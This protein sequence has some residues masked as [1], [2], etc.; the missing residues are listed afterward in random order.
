MANSPSATANRTTTTRRG[1]VGKT[2]L[3]LEVMVR[4]LGAANGRGRDDRTR[5]QNGRGKGGRLNR[6]L[7]SAEQA[8]LNEICRVAGGGKLD[9]DRES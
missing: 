8:F 5:L 3:P 9:S 6:Q 1:D 7:S 2:S 4:L